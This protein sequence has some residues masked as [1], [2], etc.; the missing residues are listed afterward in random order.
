MTDTKTTPQRQAE[1]RFKLKRKRGLPFSGA[2]VPVYLL[3]LF[4]AKT[5]EME[6]ATVDCDWDLVEALAAKCEGYKAKMAA[7]L[8]PDEK[9]A[10]ARGLVAK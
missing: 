6:Q 4:I 2:A 3:N 7:A 5:R 10:W 8:T 1:L 9:R